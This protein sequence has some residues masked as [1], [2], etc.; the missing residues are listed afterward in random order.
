MEQITFTLTSC[1]RPDLLK[2]TL[3]SFAALNTYPIARY[4]IHEDGLHA[5]CVQLIREHY[6]FFE[7]LG[8]PDRVGL[9]ASIDRLMTEVKT[10]YVFHCEDD[11]LFEGNA[12]FIKDSASLLDFS[13]KNKESFHEQIHRVWIRH[14][15][16][17]P[18]PL[19]RDD[20]C[21][22]WNGEIHYQCLTQ[23]WRGTWSG[24]SWNP[25]LI[26][27][28]DHKK[29]FPNGVSDFGDEA[30]CSRHVNE[31]GYNAVALVNS[32]CRHIGYNRHTT[33]FKV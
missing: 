29:F 23:D 17:S 6:P 1:G 10:D 18:H 12:N 13:A 9:A 30:A 33:D 20:Y 28:S 19:L 4:I 27:M 32:A 11:W 31:M 25:G 3:D 24:Y 5:E 8:S 2:R 7:I 22:Y 16:D 14:K 26:R 15:N 21:I